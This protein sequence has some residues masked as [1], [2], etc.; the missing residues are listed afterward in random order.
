[1]GGINIMKAKEYIIEEIDKILG[2]MSLLQL[3]ALLSAVR[4]FEKNTRLK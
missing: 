1:M 4:R 2:R 3:E